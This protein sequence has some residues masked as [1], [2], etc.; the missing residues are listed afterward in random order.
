MEEEK[1]GKIK[2]ILERVKIA[3]KINGKYKKRIIISGIL[4]L[5]V[6]LIVLCAVNVS[7]KWI[8]MDNIIKGLQEEPQI[9][10]KMQIANVDSEWI[11]PFEGENIIV[12]RKVFYDTRILNMKE[13]FCVIYILENEQYATLLKKYFVGIVDK[14]NEIVKEIYNIENYKNTEI[15]QNKNCLIILD[16]NLKSNKKVYINKFDSIVEQGL[17]IAKK[18]IGQ[19]EY[20]RLNNIIENKITYYEEIAYNTFIESAKNCADE[21]TKKIDGLENTLDEDVLDEIREEIEDLEERPYFKDYIPQ[22]NERLNAIENNIIQG[23]EN[24]A[25]EISGGLDTVAS[26]LDENTLGEIEKKINNISDKYYDNY[27]ENWKSRIENIKISIEQNKVTEYKKS[28]KNLT[29]TEISRSPDT[30]KG[31]RVHFTGEIVQVMESYTTVSLRVNITKKG[32][33]STYYT[34]TIY[35]VYSQNDSNNRFLEDDIIDIYGEMNGLYSYTSVMGATITL[36]RVN[37][38]YIDIR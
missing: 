2:K 19:E 12:E 9:K 23:K 28:C 21:I 36:P 8:T 34:D 14:E 18:N 15:H 24:L 4:I 38:E 17:Y 5:V 32:R 20:N 26:T 30:Y 37:A 33:Y 27:K 29:Y 31:E 25:N 7:K 1:K 11:S 6:L 16:E 10:G 3:N 13:D 22:W 35:V